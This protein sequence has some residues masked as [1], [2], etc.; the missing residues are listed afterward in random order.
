[1]LSKG[2]TQPR[3][4]SIAFGRLVYF[5]QAPAMEAGGLAVVNVEKIILALLFSAP[6]GVVA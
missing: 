4:D 6:S 2:Y 5:A 1:M 3:F